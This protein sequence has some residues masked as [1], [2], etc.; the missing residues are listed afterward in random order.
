MNM[1]NRLS[2]TLMA[3]A[4][5]AYWAAPAAAQLLYGSLTGIVEDSSGGSVPNSTISITNKGTGQTYEAKT[6]EG[7]RYT[8][9]NILPGEYDVKFAAAGFRPATVKSARIT[10]GFVSRENAKLEVGSTNETITVQ[11]EATVLQTDKSD[12]HTEL[13]AKQISSLPLPGYRNYQSLINLVP[14]ATPAGFQNSV[15]DT[16]GRS[17]ATNINGTNKNNNMTRIDGAASVNLWL[18]HH[19]GYV[20]PAEMVDTVNVTT[21]ASDAEQGTSGGASISLSTKSGTNQFHGS[22]FEFHD[23]QHLKARNFFFTPSATVPNKPLRIYNNYGATIGGPIKKNK[24]FF[25]YSFDGS[26][27]RDGAFGTY[28]VPTA[29]IRT[30]NFASTGTTIYDPATGNVTN[31]TGR[32]PFPGNL[33]PANRLS[34]QAQKIQANYPQPNLA[35]P[36]T[37]YAAVG[38]PIFKRDYNDVKINWTRNEKSQ[39]WGHYGRMKAIVVGKA[40]FGEGVGPSPGASPGTGDTRVQNMSAGHNYTLSSN[41]LL[42]GVFGYQRQ[43]Q[44]VR[45]VD[46]GQDFSTKL[47]IPGINNPADIMQS[48]FPNININGYDGF[49]V[50]GWMPLNRVEESY[51]TSHNL[52]WTKGAHVFR[53]GFD[54]VNHRMTHYQPELGGG[55]RGAF[56]FAGGS[57][58]LGPSGA[59]NNFNG[60]AAFLLGLTNNMQ[61]SIQYILMTPREFQFGWYAQDRWQVTRKLTV[62]I[63]LRYEYYPLMTRATGKGIERLEPLTNQV[64]LGGRGNQPKD[65]GITVSKKLF[66]PKIGLAYRMDDKTVFRAGYGINYDPLPFSRPLRGFYPL[67]VNFN[68][69]A[70]NSFVPVGT[71]AT[72]LPPTVGPDISSGIVNLPAVADMRSPNLGQIHRGYIQSWNATFERR[73]PMSIVGTVAYVGTQ[74]VHQLADLDINSSSPGLGNAGRPYNAKFGRQIATNMWDGYLS[75]NYHSL[76]TSI[77]KQFQ[78]GVMLQGSYTWS[79]AIN[80]TDEDGWASVGWNWGPVFNRNRALAGY[81][82]THIFNIGW[83]YELPFGKGKPYANSGVLS[84][85]VG[86]WSVNGIMAAYT[87]TPFTVGA[88]GAS[89]NIGGGNAQTADQVKSEVTRSF[90]VGPGTTWYDVD[91]FVPVTAVRF[92]STGRN[93]LR[94]PGVWNTDLLVGRTFVVTEKVKVEFRGEATN[95]QNTSHFG[96][97]ASTSVANKGNNFLSVRSAFG[98]RQVRFGLRVQF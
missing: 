19:T 36:L 53:F 87:G 13:N 40:I 50:P 22:A 38:G 24:L 81:D 96:G 8:I 93:I 71:L 66:A 58:V 34:P 47:G 64:F 60:Y 67:T 76:Q 43:D 4:I 14:G 83:V 2:V 48:G 80:M 49:G 3:L 23:N 45:G 86:G 61:K 54:G 6:D 94:N 20:M 9:Q 42:D 30:G 31:G 33:I 89:L 5:S 63:G 59:A 73:M 77:R 52:S 57:T 79:K 41:L 12:T 92:G 78:K 27:Q 21:A 55:P 62:N 70:P 37:N 17:L 29:D 39:V 25:F 74:T 44:T 91:A 88:S 82:R 65:V 98:E 46:F 75:S 10:A 95:F 35:G 11:A 28:S 16:P 69:D 97:F 18:P 84:H 32:N 51:T 68:F 1:R 90:Q 15:I 85:I 72:G 7:G 56:E 26:R